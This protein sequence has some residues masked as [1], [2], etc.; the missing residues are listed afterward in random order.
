M[1]KPAGIIRQGARMKKRTVE[2]LRAEGWEPLR[3][4][5]R[6]VRRQKHTTRALFY[7]IP[8]HAKAAD[9]VVA[10]QDG[11]GSILLVAADRL[12]GAGQ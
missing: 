7:Y 9:E 6:P 1:R 2:Q 5:L 12:I 11:N 8:T 3:V 10:F 4:P